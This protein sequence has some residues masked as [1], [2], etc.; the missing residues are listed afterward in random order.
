MVGTNTCSYILPK[1]GLLNCNC[2]N[3]LL[4]ELRMNCGLIVSSFTKKPWPRPVQDKLSCQF[5]RIMMV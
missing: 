3:G 4:C 2:I 1:W 5:L